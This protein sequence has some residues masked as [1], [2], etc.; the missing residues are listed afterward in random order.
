MK[1]SKLQVYALNLGWFI[2][3]MGG[4][5][6]FERG[7][8]SIAGIA[9]FLLGLAT[10]AYAFYTLFLERKFEMIGSA[11][12]IKINAAGVVLLMVAHVIIFIKSSFNWPLHLLLLLILLFLLYSLKKSQTKES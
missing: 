5:S 1:L 3:V 7:V 8:W 4:I 10:M 6:L 2:S 11:M 12:L 9:L